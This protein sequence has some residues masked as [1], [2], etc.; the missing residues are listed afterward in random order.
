MTRVGLI[1]RC[2]NRGIAYQTLE[3]HRHMK[4]DK[5]LLILLN[6]RQW[7]EDV[8][9]F[10]GTDVTIQQLNI[11]D[12]QYDEKKVRQF[13]DG[14]DVVFA[15]ET[16]YD[17]RLCDWARSMG[18]RTIVQA[19]PELFV[20]HLRPELSH[21]DQW[22]WPTHW[23][24]DN[25]LL[26]DGPLVPV[27]CVEMPDVAAD[28]DDDVLRILHV[29]GHAAAGDRNGTTLFVDA[30]ASLRDRVH[31]TIIGQDSWLP[32]A[33]RLGRNVTVDL[34]PVGVADRWEMYRNQHVVVLPRRYGGLCLPAL[35][36]MSSGCAILMTDCEP[37]RI[38]P[39]PRV[40]A[41]RGRV[42]RSPFGQIQ[43][44][45]VHPLR[46]ASAI[47]QFANI[48]YRRRHMADAAAYADLM[49][50]SELKPITYDPLMEG[51]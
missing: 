5:T 11:R 3:F 4:P 10:S 12:M 28:P 21:P 45:E 23:M 33:R 34:N 8:G 9:R 24:H 1:A 29:A 13:L 7:P 27:P 50:W 38:W 16:F 35:E 37:N 42:H 26:P 20:H 41:R 30:L 6:E 22:V 46:L 25:D 19:N 36:A 44:W 18:V 49:S 48:D 17:W 14:L 51:E 47:N 2:D 31:V 40:E 15:V 43:T 39:G 32:P